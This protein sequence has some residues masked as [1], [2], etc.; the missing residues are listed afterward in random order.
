MDTTSAPLADYF[1]IAGIDSLSYSDPIS[2]SQ[3]TTNLPVNPPSPSFDATI[4]EGES[5]GDT[6]TTSPTGKENR[7]PRAQ[8]R[9]SRQ[10][11][12]NRLSKLTNDSRNS[13][14]ALEELENTTRSNRSSITIKGVPASNGTIVTNGTNGSSNGGGSGLLGDFDF[15]SALL[16]FAHE[17]EHFLDDLSFAAGAPPPQRPNAF[18]AARSSTAKIAES[19][20]GF[21]TKRNQLKSVGGSIRRRISFRDMNSMKRQPTTTQAKRT[22]KFDFQ[23]YCMKLG[24]PKLDNNTRKTSFTTCQTSAD[25]YGSISLRPHIQT[26]E[27]LQL[28]DPPSRTPK[29][30]PRNASSE[31]TL[32][33]RL[34]RQI[35]AEKCN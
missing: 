6:P 27:Q 21:A 32:R 26:T 20:N 14:G 34:V 8:A 5:E 1:W 12:W 2:W 28:G 23:S 31:T 17:R 30:R 29:R 33:A 7:T 22:C 35:P 10:N 4:E 3:N 13:V 11:S 16:K 15:D 24:C 18:P 19:T 25:V 9:H